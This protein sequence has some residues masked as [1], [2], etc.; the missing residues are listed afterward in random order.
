MKSMKKIVLSMFFVLG[1]F[2]SLSFVVSAIDMVPIPKWGGG[3]INYRNTSIQMEM[4]AE[5]IE[6]ESNFRAVWVS[7]VVNDIGIYASESQY[8]SE[9]MRVFDTM[10]YYNMN[11]MIFHIRTH[12]DAMYKSNL[13]RLSPN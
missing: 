1:L 8:K 13:N 12:H 11:A 9:M 5:Y 3:Y 2:I 10:E 6:P 4:P 7:N